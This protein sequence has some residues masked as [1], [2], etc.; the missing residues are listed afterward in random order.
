MAESGIIEQE[1]RILL[2]VQAEP[3]NHCVEFYDRLKHVVTH[4]ASLIK[5]GK[6]RGEPATPDHI[7]LGHSHNLQDRTH[8]VL[9]RKEQWRLR[10]R[11]VVTR[12]PINTSLK[13]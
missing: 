8:L 10:G 4:A 11:V 13:H 1:Y 2:Q 12:E 5:W 9:V 6:H 7:R 3:M